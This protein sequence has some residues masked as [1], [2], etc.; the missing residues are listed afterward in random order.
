[1][2]KAARSR[3]A[4]G[5]LAYARARILDAERALLRAGIDEPYVARASSSLAGAYA[6]LTRLGELL[7]A[8]RR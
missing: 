7:E 8:E 1:M 2:P 3:T 4:R 6:S 5:E